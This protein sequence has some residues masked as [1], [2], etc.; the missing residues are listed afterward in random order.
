MGLNRNQVLLEDVFKSICLLVT[1]LVLRA[2]LVIIIEIPV[3]MAL[4]DGELLFYTQTS[5][6]GSF[7][8]L[9]PQVMTCNYNCF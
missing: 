3:N 1:H 9:P 5:L 8:K 6:A 7:D 4:K 2:V